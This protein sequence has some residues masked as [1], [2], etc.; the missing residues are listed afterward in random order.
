META[1]LFI[2][3]R[4]RAIRLPKSLCFSDDITEVEVY[5]EGDM[6]I[7]KPHRPGWSTFADEAP[8]VPD[9]FMDAR[10]RDQGVPQ[11]RDDWP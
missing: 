1:K 3:G 8:A 7:L 10:E 11:E 4:N 6:I 5:R 9:D 2:N